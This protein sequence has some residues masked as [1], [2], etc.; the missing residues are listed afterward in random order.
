MT[1][2]SS[3]GVQIGALVRTFLLRFFESELTS[4]PD[5]LKTTFF[6]LLAFLAVPGLVIPVDLSFA[7]TLRATLE[8]VEGLRVA[9]RGEKAF[10]LGFAMIASG[11][12]SVIAWGSLLVDR[13]DGLILGAL[14]VRPLIVLTAK[15]AALAAYIALVAAAMHTLASVS[16]GFF[17]ASRGTVGFALQGIVAHFV[18]A[19]A[20]SA[21]IL[22][23][24]VALQGSVLALFGPRLYARA[25]PVLQTL[26]VGGIAAGC[27]VLPLVD[28]STVS[29]LAGAGPANRPW[30]LWQY[31]AAGR[32]PDQPRQR[33]RRGHCQTDRHRM[34]QDQNERERCHPSVR[35]QRHEVRPETLS[36]VGRG[37]RA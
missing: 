35:A 2:T 4:T 33:Q 27:L 32:V 10:Y 13:R 12:L 28:I 29:T 20:S 19:S 22:L 17:L 24:V 37:H 26:V 34:G 6:W 9:S 36:H 21:F 15:L 14:P 16:F 7:W 8:G 1:T 30:L 3:A 31:T 23:A 25:A 5:D 18:A 11:S